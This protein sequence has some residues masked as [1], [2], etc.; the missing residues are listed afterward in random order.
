MSAQSGLGGK[1]RPARIARR[2]GSG[3]DAAAPA[4][5]DIG[6]SEIPLVGNFTSFYSANRAGVAKA[7]TLTLGD[8]EL[9]A[10]AADE[11]MARAYQRWGH[12][13]AMANPVG[14]VYRVGFNWATSVLR[15]RARSARE[16][17]YQT[18][19]TD[20]PPVSDPAVHRALAELDVKQRAVVVCRYLLGWSEQET[21]A[22][23]DLRVGTVKSRLARASRVLRVRLDH[24]RP[25]ETN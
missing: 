21:A 13:Q 25:N 16:P 22:A 1:D 3:P 8:R 10:E 20:I 2:S 14:W 15:R 19:V 12:V 9:A 18:G 7:L 23:L 4:A 6:T 24:L 11:A 5:P 17:L